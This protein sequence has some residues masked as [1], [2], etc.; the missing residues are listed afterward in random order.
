MKISKF[1]SQDCQRNQQRNGEEGEYAYYAVVVNALKNRP[2]CSKW[3]IEAAFSPTAVPHVMRGAM[4]TQFGRAFR[5]PVLQVVYSVLE[6]YIIFLDCAYIKKMATYA[7]MEVASPI[8]RPESRPLFRRGRR[9]G[10]TWRLEN[11]FLTYLQLYTVHRLPA[12]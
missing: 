9:W 10:M 5:P 3:Y 8:L 6:R 11:I 7:V 12:L 2:L 1:H 4:P